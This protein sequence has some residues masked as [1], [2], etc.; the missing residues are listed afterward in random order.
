MTIADRMSKLGHTQNFSLEAGSRTIN[1]GAMVLTAIADAILPDDRREN[2]QVVI[3]RLMKI[4]SSDHRSGL[5]A[6]DDDKPSKQNKNK[7]DWCC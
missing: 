3:A 5:G 6:Q 7:I 1:V 4:P 2:N